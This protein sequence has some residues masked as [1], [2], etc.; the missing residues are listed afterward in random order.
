MTIHVNIYMLSIMCIMYCKKTCMEVDIL[1][2]HSSLKVLAI[3]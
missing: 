1:Q 2:L 3:I